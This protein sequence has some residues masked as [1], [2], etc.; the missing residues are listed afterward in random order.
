MKRIPVISFIVPIVVTAVIVFIFSPGLGTSDSLSAAIG[1]GGGQGDCKCHNATSTPACSGC[2]QNYNQCVFKSTY[3]AQE[4]V[5]GDTW[6]CD[7]SSCDPGQKR[8][9]K[10]CSPDPC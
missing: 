5:D 4:C 6:R 9:S 1:S 3:T 2:S 7:W 10:T 8:K